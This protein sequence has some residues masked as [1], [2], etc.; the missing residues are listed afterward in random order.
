[1]LYYFCTCFRAVASPTKLSCTKRTRVN[2]QRLF[3]MVAVP[4]FL[5]RWFVRLQSESGV[6]VF[7]KYILF[8]FVFKLE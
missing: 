3:M 2:F 8:V 6:L 5:P 1:M 7:W 4:L